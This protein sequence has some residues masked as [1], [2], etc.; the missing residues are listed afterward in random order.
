ML[1][2]LG[3]LMTAGAAQPAQALEPISVTSDQDRIEITG[4]GELHVGRDDTLQIE[5][6]SG[7]DGV[8]GRMS[9]RATT[10]GT[11][12]SLSQTLMRWR[13]GLQFLAIMI[14]LLLVYLWR[15]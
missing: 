12:P 14:M 13:V 10:P 8:S 11:S 6:A 3:L 4:L 9:I 1:L 5:T 7:P 15:S 2:L